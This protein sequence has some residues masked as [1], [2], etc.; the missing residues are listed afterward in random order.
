MAYMKTNKQEKK[1][2]FGDFL[3]YDSLR[4]EQDQMKKE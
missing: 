1:L 2:Y 3:Y 4:E